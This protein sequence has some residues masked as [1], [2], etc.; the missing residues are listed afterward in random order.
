[1]TLWEALILIFAGIFAGALNTLAGGGSLI[2]LPLLIFMGLPSAD[3][4]ASNRVAIFFQNIFS[5]SG[6]KS[7]GVSV[8]PY[9]YW[10]AASAM[11]GAV[12]GAYIAVDISNH[13]FNRILAIIM[14][15]VIIVTV[16]K[17]YLYKLNGEEIFSKNRTILSIFLFFGVGIYGGF[18]QAGIGFLMIAILTNIHGLNMA[19]TNSIKVFTA[20][21]YTTLALVVFIIEDKIR[22][23]Y[24]L[25]L[26]IGNAT[27]GWLAS[28]WSVGKDDKW[29]QLI[30]IVTVIALAIKLWFYD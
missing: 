19:K 4:N 23:Q 16:L 18:I 25:T 10:V 30:M 5:V 15:L 7:K 6:F 17:P 24:G 29:I 14:V 13:V 27:G 11:V 2:T 3:A 1:M 9:A 20:L 22:W 8:F 21:S 28:R 12:I 26:S